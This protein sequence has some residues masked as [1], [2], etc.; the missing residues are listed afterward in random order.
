VRLTERAE[1]ALLMAVLMGFVLLVT[2]L[3]SLAVF[4]DYISWGDG[5]IAVSYS[6]GGCVII[7]IVMLIGILAFDLGLALRIARATRRDRA[8]QAAYFQILF[9]VLLASFMLCTPSAAFA[10][11]IAFGFP[12]LLAGAVLYPYSA[13]VMKR[14][15]KE[16]ER[17]DLILVSCW[18]CRNVF[19]MHREQEGTRCPYCG[20]LNLNPVEVK[21]GEATAEP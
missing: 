14:E 18:R 4:W 2:G 12:L 9:P 8:R 5:E 1:V 7:G 17:R 16:I 15:A 13:M 6:A 20:E 21:E 10:P 3:S 19:E 11:S